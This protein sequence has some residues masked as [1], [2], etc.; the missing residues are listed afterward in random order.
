[1]KRGLTR[2]EKIKLKWKSFHIKKI[3]KFGYARK[4]E[5]EKDKTNW[6]RGKRFGQKGLH[7]THKA[8]DPEPQ[9]GKDREGVGGSNGLFW[10]VK[11]C[12]CCESNGADDKG[13]ENNYKGFRKKIK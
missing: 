3:K 7:Y 12:P 10:Q 5:M 9:L 8:M 2:M 6:H 1:M 13:V 4:D 11:R